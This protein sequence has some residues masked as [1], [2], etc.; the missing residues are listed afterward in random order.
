MIGRDE[1]VNKM[2][3]IMQMIELYERYGSINNVAKELNISRNTIKSISIR[4]NQF[5]TWDSVQAQKIFEIT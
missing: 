5:F 1:E 4:F 3:D 2:S